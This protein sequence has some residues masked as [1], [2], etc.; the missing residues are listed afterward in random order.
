MPDANHILKPAVS[1]LITVKNGRQYICDAIKSVVNQ[2]I[3]DWEMIVVDDGSTDGTIEIIENLAQI[4]PRIKLILTGGIGRGHALNLAVSSA[5]A[6]LLAVL[7]ADDLF[8]PQKLSFQINALTETGADAACTGRLAFLD[9]QVPC[10]SNDSI[11]RISLSYLPWYL[12]ANGNPIC[13]SSVLIRKSA[14]L[15]LGC[16]NVDRLSHFDYDL[17][18][19]MAKSDL[20]MCE[21]K[22]VLTYKRIHRLQHFGASKRMSYAKNSALLQYQ[23]LQMYKN[24]DSVG[25]SSYIRLFIRYIR[26]LVPLH[27]GKIVNRKINRS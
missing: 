1:V 11:D 2:S 24:H 26:S 10:A 13:H 27:I 8:H 5:S 16:Y 25:F 15:D 7:D 22:E 23:A 4:E 19:R 17:W 9:N 21:I 6:D 14:L 18:L 20:R 3:A 12:L